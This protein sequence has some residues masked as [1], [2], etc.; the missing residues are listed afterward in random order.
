[1]MMLILTSWRNDVKQK[2]VWLRENIWDRVQEQVLI[3]VPHVPLNTSK[4]ICRWTKTNKGVCLNRWPSSTGNQAWLKWPQYSWKSMQDAW[5]M[6]RKQPFTGVKWD[7][8]GAQVLEHKWLL[9]DLQNPF[10]KKKKN[11]QNLPTKCF[12]HTPDVR[13]WDDW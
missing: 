6:W 7:R 3:Q 10:K 8:T 11:P 9:Q 1:M 12:H 5:M 2:Q 13:Y 4:S